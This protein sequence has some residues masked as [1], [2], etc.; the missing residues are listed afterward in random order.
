M[1]KLSD[2]NG[3]HRDTSWWKIGLSILLVI[4]IPLIYVF[5]IAPVMGYILNTITT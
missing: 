1:E 2:F 3:E 5:F 4:G